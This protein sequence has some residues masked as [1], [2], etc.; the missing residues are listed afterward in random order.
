MNRDLL[1]N[2]LT[3][4]VYVAALV[5]MYLDLFVWRPN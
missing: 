5:V 2:I 1:I 3:C 4:V